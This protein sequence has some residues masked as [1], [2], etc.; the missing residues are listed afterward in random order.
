M[1]T[2]ADHLLPRA[3][4]MIC[5][6]IIR[7][8][9]K[10]TSSAN[11][12]SPVNTIKTVLLSIRMLLELPNPD[13]PQ[14]AVVATMARDEPE[15]FRLMAHDWAVRYA[16][17][18]RREPPPP[19]QPSERAPQPPKKM[20]EVDPA[21]YKGYNK[22]MVDQFVEMGFDIDRVVEAFLHFGLD[23]N[24]GYHYQMEEAYAGDI[25][26]RLYGEA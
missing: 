1:L 15:Y 12:W 24:G 4:G 7:P 25:I 6:D 8:N 17:A 19:E 20:D 3:Q 21:R 18:P 10:S 26:S 11:T 14:D 22:A 5:L 2:T 16:G 9:D 23:R 13:D